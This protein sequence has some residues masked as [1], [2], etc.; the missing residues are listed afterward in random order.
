MKQLFFAILFPCL[1]SAQSQD[2]RTSPIP[3]TDFGRDLG[4]YNKRWDSTFARY[5]TTTAL[6]FGYSLISDG[7][8][9]WYRSGDAYSSLWQRHATFTANR[10]VTIPNL[11]G[12]LAFSDAAQNFTS[13]GTIT[14]GLINS[15]TISSAANFTG[16]LGVTGATTLSEKTTIQPTTG[17]LNEGALKL[18]STGA[19]NYVGVSFWNGNFAASADSRNWQ[20]ATNYTSFGDLQVLR[21]TTASGNPTTAALTFD[22]AGAATFASSVAGSTALRDTSSFTTTATR[23]AVYVSGLTS[24]ANVSVSHRNLTG[25]D[26]LPVADDQL[27]YYVKVDSLIVLRQAGTTSGQKFSFHIIY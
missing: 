4:T 3:D 11:D 14:S 21:S 25:S 10:T 27:S 7:L 17:N 5:S 15:Q 8:A 22:K 6:N 20:I 26:T 1:L 2:F 19:I 13:V 23:K 9:R 24:T 12:T 16:T 18:L